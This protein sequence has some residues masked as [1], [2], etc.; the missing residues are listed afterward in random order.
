M[1]DRAVRQALHSEFQFH[2][3]KIAVVQEL[4][5]PDFALHQVSCETMIETLPQN[6]IVYFSDKAHIHLSE[7]R[8][9]SLVSDTNPR[10]LH[11]KP[12]HLEQRTIWQFGA[13]CKKKV[14]FLRKTIVL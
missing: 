13:H 2:P 10:E 4:L 7:Y 1:S 3:F 5:Q 14:T 6:E 11:N 9:Y 12:F 8:K